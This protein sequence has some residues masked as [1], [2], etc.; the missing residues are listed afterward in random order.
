M[1]ATVAA[2]EL[3]VLSVPGLD[4][5]VEELEPLEAPDFW[6]GFKTGLTLGAAGGA[7]FGTGIGIGVAIT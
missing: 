5:G 4:L 7:A 1:F 6:D 3:S 2:P